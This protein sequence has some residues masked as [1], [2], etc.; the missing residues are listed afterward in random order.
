MTS[1]AIFVSRLTKVDDHTRSDHAY[2]AEDDVCYFIAEYTARQGYAYSA[3][4]QSV[5]DIQKTVDPS[6][7]TGVALQGTGDS[8]RCGGLPGSGQVRGS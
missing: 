3:T 1:G 2:L 7:P 6:R 5:Y 4:K 8:N